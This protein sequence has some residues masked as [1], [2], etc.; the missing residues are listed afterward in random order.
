MQ[1]ASESVLQLKSY[2]QV[3][4]GAQQTA[5]GEPNPS[6]ANSWS[7]VVS[8]KQFQGGTE[9]GEWTLRQSTQPWSWLSGTWQVMGIA[10]RQPCQSWSCSIHHQPLPWNSFSD[11]GPFKHCREESALLLG[12]FGCHVWMRDTSELLWKENA[13]NIPQTGF[14]GAHLTMGS[15]TV[16]E[17][18]CH[19]LH[20]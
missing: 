16:P 13:A 7:Y 9:E 18:R 15:W 12:T 11:P 4:K 14:W 1:P 17:L 2:G 5:Q 6:A 20:G 3:M 8:M 19:E 10:A